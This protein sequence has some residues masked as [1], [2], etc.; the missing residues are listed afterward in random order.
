MEGVYTRGDLQEGGIGARAVL[1]VGGC[2]SLRAPS[3]LGHT[4]A[5]PAAI[6][7]S[8]LG[9]RYSTSTKLLKPAMHFLPSAD[10]WRPSNCLKPAKRA[11]LHPETVRNASDGAPGGRAQ[12]WKSGGVYIAIPGCSRDS[13]VSL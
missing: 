1:A 11:W 5:T 4:I 13:R 3:G 12:P 2:N 9:A 7:P 6:F 8:P 10:R